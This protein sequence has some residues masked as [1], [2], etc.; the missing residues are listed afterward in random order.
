MLI[1]KDKK[2]L[3]VILRIEANAEATHKKINLILFLRLFHPY[4]Q[5]SPFGYNPFPN[6][7][8]LREENFLPNKLKGKEG[9]T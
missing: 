4:Y 7:S 6:G 3:T 9:K 1:K 5:K 2:Y 8:Y